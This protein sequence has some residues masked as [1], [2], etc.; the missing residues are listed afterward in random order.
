MANS[1]PACVAVSRRH[2]PGRLVLAALVS[3][4]VAACSGATPPEPSSGPTSQPTVAV[5]RDYWPTAGWRTAASK[6]HGIDTAPVEDALT[7]AYAHVRSVLLVCHGYL[8]YEHYRH[9]LDETSGHDVRSVTKSVIGAL[10]GIAL[11][12]GKIKSLEQTVGEFLSA[13]LSKDADARVAGATVRQLLTMTSGLPA[14][15]ANIDEEMWNSPDW[16]SYIS[17]L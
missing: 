4:L 8:V 2:I 1:Y 7:S 14:N 3:F 5:V 13:Q 12:E 6:D 17:S 11:A 16:V 10:V 9:G 15:A